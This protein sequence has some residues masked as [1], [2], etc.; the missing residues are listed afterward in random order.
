MQNPMQSF[1]AFTRHC[2]FYGIVNP[3]TR[4]QWHVTIKH[5]EE[6]TA[7]NIACDVLNGHSYAE[8]VSLNLKESNNES[9]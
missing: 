3:F 8:S 7:Y 5:L 6:K 4:L 9:L 1:D 2:S